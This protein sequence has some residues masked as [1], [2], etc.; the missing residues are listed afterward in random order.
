MLAVMVGRPGKPIVL[1]L[2]ALGLALLFSCET[3]P[4]GAES[5][6]SRFWHGTSSDPY[7]KV[8]SEAARLGDKMVA[9]LG[10]V[11][12]QASGQAAVPKV[13]TIAAD[14]EKLVVRTIALEKAEQ[15]TSER[16]RSKFGKRL[17]AQANAYYTAYS[18]LKPGPFRI[19]KNDLKKFESASRR[20][21]KAMERA[22]ISVDESA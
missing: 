22:G 6:A 5:S 18:E 3:S 21:G 12:D 2:F 19:L 7:E 17:D 13:R 4:D 9:L 14:V 20:L 1:G 15:A 10:A 11:D 16:I 8:V